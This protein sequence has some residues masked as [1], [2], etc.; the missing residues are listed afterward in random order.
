MLH[1]TGGNER[2]IAALATLLD[3]TADV[4]APRGRVIENGML[5]WFRRYAEGV[6]DLD[7][8]T[9]EA[10]ALAGFVEWA[11]EFYDLGD[12]Q[13]TAVGVSNGANIALATTLLHPDT[14]GRVISFS[15]MHPL[16]GRQVAPDLSGVEI[17]LLNG[18][19]DPMAPSAS[20]D[21]LDQQ[22]RAANATVERITRP[23][24]HGVERS[25]IEA[26]KRWVGQL[27]GA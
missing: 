7:S 27:A 18:A 20:V 12:R 19:Q 9:E 23:G 11:R 17:L 1:G 21:Q 8:V 2:Q 24:G 26:A 14:V 10:A 25:E 15:G 16:P 13:L 22:L 4:L 3:P 5:R 6:F